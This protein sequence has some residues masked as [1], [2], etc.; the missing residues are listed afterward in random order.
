MAE[1]TCEHLMVN[2]HR[3]NTYFDQDFDPSPDDCNGECDTLDID[4]R[5]RSECNVHWKRE[6]L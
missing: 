6:D 1:H 5:V 3:T 4:V 2:C